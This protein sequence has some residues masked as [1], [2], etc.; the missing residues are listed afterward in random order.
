ML[1]F[2]EFIEEMALR[3]VPRALKLLDYFH[4]KRK[5]W[6][7]DE[8]KSIVP[9]SNTRPNNN[10][11]SLYK[12]NR[13]KLQTI[14]VKSIVSGQTHVSKDVLEKKIKGE[15]EVHDPEHPIVIHHKGKHYL[16]DGNHRVNTARFRGETHIEARVHQ[17]NKTKAWMNLSGGN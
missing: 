14:S 11:E 13:G 15:W 3:D 12:R 9:H 10:I 2:N 1:S 4:K 16:V 8:M 7:P 17:S 5:E 6:A